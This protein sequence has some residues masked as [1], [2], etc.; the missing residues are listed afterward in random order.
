MLKRTAS[1]EA[2]DYFLANPRRS[3]ELKRRYGTPKRGGLAQ[4]VERL[5]CTEKVSG[6]TP[7]AS[8]LKKGES[9]IRN[10][11]FKYVSGVIVLTTPMGS[12]PER[13]P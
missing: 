9:H 2:I 12:K 1:F 6:S 8:S 4:L 3:I 13:Q 11:P 10:S 7:L 5:L